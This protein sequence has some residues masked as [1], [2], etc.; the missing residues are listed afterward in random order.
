LT[1]WKMSSMTHSSTGLSRLFH[2]GD[3]TP[4]YLA[5][6]TSGVIVVILVGRRLI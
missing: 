2:L 6:L 1:T 5:G 4:S 3:E